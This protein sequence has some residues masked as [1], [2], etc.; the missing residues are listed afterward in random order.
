MQQFVFDEGFG[1]F[2]ARS[3]VA[4]LGSRL[5][6]ETDDTIFIHERGK[7]TIKLYPKRREYAEMPAA[8]TGD[9]TIEPEEIAKRENMAFK[10]LGTEKVGEYSCR[11]I[12]VTYK[13]ERLKEMRFV[14]C[15]APE[16]KNLIVM[17]Q[18]FMGPVTMATVL[19]DVTL[20]VPEDLFR[21][22]TNYKKVI[23]KSYEEKM[24]ERLD[25]LKELG[26]PA[27]RP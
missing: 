25:R 22:P 2:G 19:G 9:F 17:R 8:E 20:S 24:K 10:S 13:D 3:K 18:M 1:G 14:F 12:E 27:K 7:P 15:A 16:L 26:K 6:E 11:K 23:E 5:R 21:L 4:K